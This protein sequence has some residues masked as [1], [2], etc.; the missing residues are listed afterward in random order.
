[1]KVWLNP[2]RIIQI[3]SIWNLWGFCKINWLFSFTKEGNREQGT[4]NR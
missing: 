1:M 2:Y 3:L 4:G